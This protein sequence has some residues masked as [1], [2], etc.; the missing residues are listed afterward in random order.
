MTGWHRLPGRIATVMLATI[1]VFVLTV[2]LSN[3]WLG[4]ALD[5]QA[6]DQSMAQIRTA[7]DNLLTQVQLTT[8]DY[9]KWGT[10]VDAI[11]A[12]DLGWVYENIGAG[13]NTGQV[14]HL[15]VIWGGRYA[16]DLGWIDDGVEVGQPGL[17]DP[18]QLGL[19]E[20]RLAD[21]P[22]GSF[23]VAAF[24]AWR[25]G[26]LHAVGAAR[27]EVADEGRDAHPEDAEIERLLMGRRVSD[28]TIAGIADSF[29]VSGLTIVGEAPANRPSVPLLG[30]N[31]EPTAFLAWD[32]PHPGTKMLRRAAPVLVLV[33]LLT[34]VLAALGMA[35]VRRS[36]QR[37][38]LAEHQSATAARTDG[39]TGLPNRLAFTEELD[40]SARAGERSILFLDVN[41][42]KRIN[43]SLG[44]AAGDQ[45]II[46]LARRLAKFTAADCFFARLAG[47][48]FMFVVTAPD[49][50]IQTKWLAQA[51]QGEL[52][53][54]VDV[55]GHQLRI[56]VAMGYAIQTDDGP[57]G[58][59]LVRQADLAMYEAKRQ[60]G[61]DPVAF[62]TLIE[63]ASS[64]ALAIEKG[65]RSALA[66]ADEF[67]IVYQPIV[68]MDGQL[69]HAEALA[70]WTSPELGAISPDRFI[71]VAEQAGLIVELG[72]QLLHLV[73]DDLVAHPDLE[74][75]VN[76]STLQLMAPDF[77]PSLVG[78]LQD[79]NIDPARIE[80][81]VTE[82]VVV[83]DSRLAAERLGEL[84]A[85]GFSIALDDFGTGYSSVGY[86]DQF[87]FDTLKIDRSFVSRIRN[88][89]KGVRVV[90]AI[91]MM[92]HGLD[93]RVV[94]EGVETAEEF[95]LLRE[96]DCDLAQGYHLDRPLPI[97]ALA[98]RWLC[99]SVAHAVV[100]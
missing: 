3:A 46:N 24:F 78:E 22:L 54:P 43:D 68:R 7:R 4:R 84:R 70:R 96:L 82:A 29:L 100:A 30:G 85:A 37:L 58:D 20:R 93:L 19:A 1:L 59:G 9:A 53:I 80:I 48:E 63:Q 35:L 86:L 44:H 40:R 94:C 67:C 87:R 74:V 55:L 36:A 90:D 17:L 31:G 45:V 10:A 83:D 81:E 42:F 38:V 69:V 50:N 28:E 15:A 57:A 13:A 33:V 27:L 72:R 75:S 2:G 97:Q 25:D 51:V 89:D 76:I 66:R 39:L 12:A 65:L 73:C 98:A 8:I 26:T 18:A 99:P 88:S 62:S 91:I 16:E 77:I 79:R 41:H 49:V 34:A 52:S 92:A 95:D 21:L 5:S 14:F 47:D 56:S 23:E 71:A 61:R 64:Q 11:D 60:A 32:M 6:R